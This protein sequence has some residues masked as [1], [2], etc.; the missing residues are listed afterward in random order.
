MGTDVYMM[1]SPGLLFVLILNLHPTKARLVVDQ[2][3]DNER[4]LHQEELYSIRRA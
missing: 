2:A 3:V 4:A 1:T